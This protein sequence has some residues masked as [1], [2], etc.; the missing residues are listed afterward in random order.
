MSSKKHSDYCG[1]WQPYPN[2]IRARRRFQQFEA[3][4][5]GGG[6]FGAKLVVSFTL[7]YHVAFYTYQL[8]K[9]NL[10]DRRDLVH[11]AWLKQK[12]STSSIRD[13]PLQNAE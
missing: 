6:L 12:F 7:L 9:T 10:E 1:F 3:M 8:T 11:I 13:S 5:N 4:K 2:N